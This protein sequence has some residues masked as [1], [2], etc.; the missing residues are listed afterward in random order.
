MKEIK[1]SRNTALLVLYISLVLVGTV[2]FYYYEASEASA[3]PVSNKNIVIDPGHGGSDPGK[4]A[5]DGTE[6]KG[7][8]LKIASYLQGFLEQGGATVT[9]TRTE[10]EAVGEGKR[11]DLKNRV[12]I[13]DNS[14]M[15]ISIHQNSYPKSNVTGAQVFYNK[16]SEDSKKLAIFIQK[17]LKEVVENKN[18]RAAKANSNYYVLK[19]I[20]IPGVIVECGFL[21][22]SIEKEKLQ[23]PQYQEKIAWAIYMGVL[24]YYGEGFL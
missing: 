23:S 19:E 24:D 6:E 22:N 21:S 7:I 17:R 1:F 9:T 4:V 2:R 20:D 5:A 18:E 12:K 10:D 11:E 15:F 16:N 3:M 8:N 13:A 14:D